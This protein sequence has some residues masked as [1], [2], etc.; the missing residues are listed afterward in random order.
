MRAFLLVLLASVLSA[1]GIE[2][3]LAEFLRVLRPG[4]R[5]A[6][7]S[8]TTLHPERDNWYE[9]LYRHLPASLAAYALGGCRPV[10]LQNAVIAA[11]FTLPYPS[12]PT[13]LQLQQALRPYPQYKTVNTGGAYPAGRYFSESGY[14]SVEKRAT[15]G[16]SLSSAGVL[17]GTPQSGARTSSFTVTADSGAPLWTD[18]SGRPLLTMTREGLGLHYRFRSRFHPGWSELVLRGAFPE[19]LARVWI[20]PGRSPSSASGTASR[21]VKRF[22]IVIIRVSRVR[23]NDGRFATSRRTGRPPHQIDAIGMDFEQVSGRA[24]ILGRIEHQQPIWGQ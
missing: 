23:G 20:G 6:L 12:Y 13:N 8:M 22:A 2:D 4:G 11:G 17:S 18:G 16:L 9:R 24:E 21:I 14:V 7:V 19:A 3:A 15:A 1:A 10:T 5:L